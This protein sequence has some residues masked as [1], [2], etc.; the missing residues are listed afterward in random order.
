[1]TY[2]PNDYV[3]QGESVI[4]RG[5]VSHYDMRYLLC[6]FI[7][8]NKKIIKAGEDILQIM[9]LSQ[10]SFIERID[11][12]TIGVRGSN[13]NAYMGLAFSESAEKWKNTIIIEISKRIG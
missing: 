2:D 13:K 10:V 6:D 11:Q 1:M 8:T 5:T 9:P 7:L 4:L 12:Y 3:G